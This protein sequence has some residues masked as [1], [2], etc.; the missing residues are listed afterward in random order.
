M[1]R[2]LMFVGS[3]NRPTPYFATANGK[4][5]ASF[6][7]DE[8]TGACLPAGLAEG[9]DNPTYLAVSRDGTRLFAVSEVFGWNEGTVTAFS[10]DRASG[11]LAYLDKQAARGDITAHLAVDPQD[12]YVAC[13]NYSM[14]PPGARPGASV[15][16]FPRLADGGLGPA[17]CEV[18]HDGRGPDAV[19][20]ERS[21]A[22]CIRWLGDGRLALVADLGTDRV[23]LYRF[24]PATG[25]LRHASGVE[26]PAGSGPRHLDLHP[27][28]PVAYL[29]NELTSTVAGIAVDP[30]AATATLGAAQ[31]TRP[32]GAR[33]ENLAAA[34]R[35]SPDARHLYVTNRGDDTV[36]IFPLDGTGIA[37]VSAIIPC[38]GRT[39]RDLAV[40]PSGRLL[41]VAN[42]DSDGISLFHRDP[43][44]GGLR[45]A[46]ATVPAGAPTC[47]AF[48]APREG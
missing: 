36:A 5:I 2:T 15:A 9:I 47:I 42:Q 17:L 10:I 35:I 40:S 33:G 43:L 34:I 11:R 29:V 1:A 14:L 22:H 38:G 16:V 24:D 28:A 21:H 4:G 19:R 23:E 41:A 7:V 3:C 6:F 12:R 30:A 31:S 32:P 25:Q 26:V 13:A 48:V 44:T 18:V 45:H 20:Q 37:A 27:H 46:G 39:P 8:E